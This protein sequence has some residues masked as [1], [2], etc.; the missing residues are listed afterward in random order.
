M[1]ESVHPIDEVGSFDVH[2]S[3]I[4]PLEGTL[5]CFNHTM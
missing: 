5:V 3:S 1:D 2:G 4:A